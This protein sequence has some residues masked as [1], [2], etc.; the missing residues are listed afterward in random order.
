MNH[1]R[2]GIV[3][4]G[5]MGSF[6]AKSLS[7]IDN[8]KLTAVCSPFPKETEAASQ[9]FAVPGFTSTNNLFAAGLIDALLIATPHMQHA[10][11]AIAA[12][13][14]GVHVLCEKPIAVTIG[15]ARRVNAAAAKHPDLTFGIM[16]QQRTMPLYRTLRQ[17]LAEGSL[18]EISRITWLVTDW[19][20]T[21]SYYASGGWRAT[22]AG[23]GGGVLIN[24]CPHNLDLIQW[25]TGLSPSRVTAIASI[26]KTHPIEVEDEVSAILEYPGGAIGHFVTSTGEAPGTNRLEVCT[27]RGKIIAENGKLVFHETAQSVRLVRETSTEPFAQ[28][29]TTVREIEIPAGPSEGHQIITQNFVNAILHGERLIAPGQDGAAALELGNAMQMAGLTRTAVDLPLDADAFDRFI[30]DMTARYGG[31]K[32]LKTVERGPADMS[33]SFK[34]P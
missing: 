24:Q 10:E 12:L 2:F 21:W 28:I 32:K 14:A 13:D 33:A 26:G 22:W 9:K 23:E 16:F 17:L 19:F 29:P 30:A 27:D 31:K 7:S 20:R 8:A 3:G 34:A 6:H 25:I 15:D 4:L 1:V 5:N 18:G 11:I